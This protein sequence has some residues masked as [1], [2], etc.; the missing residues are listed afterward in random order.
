M[1][2]VGDIEQ[3]EVQD[4]IDSITDET[5]EPFISFKD[6]ADLHKCV[7]MLENTEE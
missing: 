1:P 6:I 5:Y 2:E 4:F 7:A 3:F